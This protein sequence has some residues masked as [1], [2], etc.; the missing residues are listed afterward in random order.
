MVKSGRALA[1][2]IHHPN[3]YVDVK[4]WTVLNGDNFALILFSFPD[5]R[6]QFPKI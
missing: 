6:A 2:S 1:A 5:A 3:A 4:F